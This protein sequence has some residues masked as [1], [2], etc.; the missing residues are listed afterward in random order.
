MSKLQDQGWNI[1]RQR[2]ARI[3]SCEACVND[4]EFVLIATALEVEVTD[5]LPK[6]ESKQPLYMVL[7][8]LLGGQ[9]KTL[10]SPEDIL[11]D[12]SLRALPIQI[13]EQ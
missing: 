1:C 4:Y 5:L 13:H 10:A 9:V 8:N 11:A 2:I 6:L 7:S 12:R 3:E